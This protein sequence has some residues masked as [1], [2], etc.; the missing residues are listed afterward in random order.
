MVK[1]SWGVAIVRG[2]SMEPT[3]VDGDRVMVRY[4][5]LPQLN[6]ITVVR[7]DSV[8]AIKRLT[9]RDSNGWWFSRD[10]PTEGTDSWTRG[11]A[12]GQD[13]ILGTVRLRL[14]PRPRLFSN[15]SPINPLR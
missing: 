10:N 13:D 15:R 5:C 3:L 2:H 8:V 12:S 4:G 11:C 1:H 9:L 6:D 14:W 7:F